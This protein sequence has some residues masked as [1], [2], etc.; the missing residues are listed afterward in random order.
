[1]IPVLFEVGGLP[2][3]MEGL[4]NSGDRQSWSEQEDA[5]NM[6]AIRV[7]RRKM[8]RYGPTICGYEQVRLLLDPHEKIGVGRPGV[9]RAWRANTDHVDC[10]IH[11]PEDPLDPAIHMFVEEKSRPG[12]YADKAARSPASG[13]PPSPRDSSRWRSRWTNSRDSAS[14]RRHATSSSSSRRLR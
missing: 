8:T 1:M 6:A 7:V 4:R 9:R 12:H 10:R 14:S 2:N 5:R 11:T 3:E 13:P